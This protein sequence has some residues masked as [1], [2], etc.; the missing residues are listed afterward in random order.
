[1]FAVLEEQSFPQLGLQLLQSDIESISQLEIGSRGGSSLVRVIAQGFV[2]VNHDSSA[3]PASPSQAAASVDQD[4][5]HPGAKRLPLDGATQ[6]AVGG[7]EGFLESILRVFAVPQIAP[8]KAAKLVV[9]GVHERSESVSVPI[10]SSSDERDVVHSM[11]DAKGSSISVKNSGGPSPV[12]RF[13]RSPG[14]LMCRSRIRLQG[15]IHDDAP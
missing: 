12:R 13:Y 2:V 3:A 10:P 14:L 1:A 15:G 5:E 4:A 8:G 7:E 6:A 9:V 11:V